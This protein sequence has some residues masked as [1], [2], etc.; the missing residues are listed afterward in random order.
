MFG[1]ARW[2]IGGSCVCVAA[3]VFGMNL[4]GQ[5][6]ETAPSV[7]GDKVTLA[8]VPIGGKTTEEVTKVAEDLAA[9]LLSAPVVVREGRRSEQT[10]PRKLGAEVKTDDAVSA[11]FQA[12]SERGNLIDRIRVKFTGPDAQDV[13]LAVRVAPEGV[14]RGLRRFSERLGTEP[15]NARLTKVNGQFRSTPSKPGRKLDAAA[16]AKALQTALDKPEFR[17]ELAASVADGVSEAEWRKA[18]SPLTLKATTRAADA[19]VTL[20]DLEPITHR[21]ATYS[22]S[23]GSSSR[24]RVHNIRLASRAIDGTVV[25]PG[26][27]FSYNDVVGHRVASAGYREAPVIIEGQL[28]SGIAGGICQVSTTLYNAGLL[29]DLQVVRRS[30]HAFPVAYVP[31]GRDATVV[32]GA[33]DLRLKNRLEHPIALDTKVVGSKMVVHIYG[34]P[35]D[36]REVDILR[37]GGARYVVISRVVK[38]DG[39]IIRREVVSRDSYRPKPGAAPRVASSATTTPRRRRTP[40]R[41]VRRSP[42]GPTSVPS[43]PAPP[44]A[45]PISTPSAPADDASQSTPE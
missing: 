31:S 2:G 16:L 39:K 38:Q 20:K 6:P 45:A 12:S 33:I 44:A 23:L 3:L 30:H 17:A 32:D 13:P 5:V 26:R 10:T 41:T 14:S 21:L 1:W 43:A 29:A 27:T 11:V 9:R 18:Q 22:T 8:G 28:Q 25:L 7:A 35:D 40:S 19:E 4:R 24:N 15:V 42:A 37:R 36:Q 34:H